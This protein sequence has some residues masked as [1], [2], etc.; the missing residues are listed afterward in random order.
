MEY[1]IYSDE[2]EKRGRFYSN[3]YGGTLV[4]YRDLQE[5]ERA[6]SEVKREHFGESEAK[7]T[8]VTQSYLPRYIELIR[9]YF[10]FVRE[11]RLKVRVMFTQNL[12]VP[13]G[14]SREQIRA[15]YNLLYYQFIKHAFGLA[16]IDEPG[17]RHV[18]RLYVDDLPV[19]DEQKEVFKSCISGLSLNPRFESRGVVFPKDQIAEVDSHRHVIMQCNDLVLGAMAFRLN[20]R[21]LEKAEGQTH[22]GGRTMAKAALY[23]EIAAQIRLIRPGFNIG[24]STGVGS[25]GYL[26][27]WRDPYRHWLFIPK[28]SERNR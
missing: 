6:L 2:S 10:I 22:R 23:Q 5:V 28:N 9:S 14:L 11:G 18:V 13:V 27:R 21:H 16:Y 4:R 3:F 12:N 1:I 7:W 15:E 8:K 24:I 19:N 20:K 25:S 17:D 26:S